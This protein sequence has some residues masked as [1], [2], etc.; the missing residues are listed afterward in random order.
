MEPETYK[1]LKL[2]GQGSFGKAFL[3]ECQSDKVSYPLSNPFLCAVPRSDKEDPD[4]EHD[5]RREAIDLP[6]SQVP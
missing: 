5:D 6:R 2:L 4:K 1:K 3:V